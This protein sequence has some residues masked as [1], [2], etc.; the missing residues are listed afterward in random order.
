LFPNAT[1]AEPKRR[2]FGILEDD[3]LGIPKPP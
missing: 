3:C 1:R 2:S